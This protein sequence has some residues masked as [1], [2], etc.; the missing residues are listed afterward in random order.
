MGIDETGIVVSLSQGKAL[1][2]MEEGEHCSTCASRSGCLQVE[3]SPNQRMVEVV[4]PAGAQ[5]GQKVQLHIKSTDIIKASFTLFVFPL[6][7]LLSGALL[8]KYISRHFTEGIS[9]LLIIFSGL[10][11]MGVAFWGIRTYNRKI[12]RRE[13]YYPYITKVLH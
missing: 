2:K 7:S 9:N 6:V 1:V 11:F 13:N 12:E 10:G 8:G 3:S 4:N 5:I